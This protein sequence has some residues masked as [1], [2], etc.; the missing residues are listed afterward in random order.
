M[1]RQ[2]HRPMRRVPQ[3]LGVQPWRGDRRTQPVREAGGGFAL[4]GQEGL[5][6]LGQ[7]VQLPCHQA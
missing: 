4:G 3:P 6:T 2:G 5:D 1:E 7:M